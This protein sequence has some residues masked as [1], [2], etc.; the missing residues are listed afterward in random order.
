MRILHR[1]HHRLTTDRTGIDRPAPQPG[2]PGTDPLRALRDQTWT[3][4]I[5]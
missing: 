5:F 4:R 3:R 1:L 2:P